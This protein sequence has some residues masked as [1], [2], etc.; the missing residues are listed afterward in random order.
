MIDISIMSSNIAAQNVKLCAGWIQED[1]IQVPLRLR[2]TAADQPTPLRARFSGAS[3]RRGGGAAS[4]P[5]TPQPLRQ[6]Y[7][8]DDTN[9]SA[10]SVVRVN[11]CAAHSLR[12]QNA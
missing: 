3:A 4:V 7:A 11:Q 6:R 9:Q 2:A 10:T 1:E 12:R 8:A 5:E